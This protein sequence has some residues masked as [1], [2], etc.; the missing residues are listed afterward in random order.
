M[1]WGDTPALLTRTGVEAVLAFLSRFEQP[2]FCPGVWIEP[3]PL[4]DGSLQL[5]WF[6]YDPVVD[7][8]RQALAENG[9]FISFP[10]TEWEDFEL[11]RRRPA[12]LASADLDTLRMV[13]TVMVRAERFSEGSLAAVFESGLV[14]AVLRRAA[15]LYEW[16][17][18][19]E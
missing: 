7:G 3:P 15:Q 4:P 6:Q 19:A 10:W 2:E 18:P 1:P 8:F 13:M 11:Y 9:W 5:G 14:V 16:G 17:E 12:L